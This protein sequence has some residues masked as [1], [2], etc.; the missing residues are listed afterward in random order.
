MKMFFSPSARCRIA[1]HDLPGPQMPIVFLHG[2]G[3]AGTLDYPAVAGN[4]AL[5]GHRRILV[6]LP[7]HGASDA[8]AGFDYST[9]AMACIAEELVRDL[10][11]TGRVA[12]FGH[13]MGGSIAIE[14]AERLG[15]ACGHLVLAEA[16]LDA[17]G[18]LLSA[19]IADTEEADFALRGKAK[20]IGEK[21]EREEYASARVFEIA[22]ARALH[23]CAAALASGATP[24]WFDKL[25]ALPTPKTMIHSETH[26]GH[27][28]VARLE[29][30]AVEQFFLKASG[31][32]MPNDNPAGLARLIGAI[33]SL[34][35][36]K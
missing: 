26:A 4:P 18:G 17:G 15:D 8:P 3:G 31:H 30:T 23:C 19:R 12:L 7:G 16:N 1:Y 24:S 14:L 32:D 5:S 25:A 35:G 34:E 11:P 9:G 33:L 10:C 6:D 36:P 22:D 20:I 28:D 27:K 13:S 2:L 29:P 21:S